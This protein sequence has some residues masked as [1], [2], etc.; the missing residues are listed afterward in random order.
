VARFSYGAKR[1]LSV[2]QWATVGADDS[3]LR[4]TNDSARTTIDHSIVNEPHHF[5]FALR[6]QVVPCTLYGDLRFVLSICAVAL[7]GLANCIEQ[8]L[9]AKGFGQKLNRT[10]LH[11]L[12]R[13]RDVA[14]AGEKD[15][16]NRKIS[17]NLKALAPAS[18][19]DPILI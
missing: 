3:A 6:Q 7:D 11:R 9:V 8:L 18:G 5:A 16:R 2:V 15:N 12:H 10:G 13:H 14:M 1:G 4:A 19:S 17:R